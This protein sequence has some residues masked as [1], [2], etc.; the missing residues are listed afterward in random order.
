MAYKESWGRG[1]LKTKKGLSRWFR[2][3]KPCPTSGL[4]SMS[5]LWHVSTCL[6]ICM[7]NSY[8]ACACVE[9]G[10][11][12]CSHPLLPLTLSGREEWTGRMEVAEMCFCVPFV[13]PLLMCCSNGIRRKH[14][15]SWTRLLQSFVSSA[16]VL[17]WTVI[18]VWDPEEPQ[19]VRVDDTAP[20]RPMAHCSIRQL[21][22]FFK[23]SLY[24]NKIN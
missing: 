11:M 18:L 15:D 2:E 10:P 8:K 1:L 23:E 14:V 20:D 4:H 19:P 6:F 16:K 13:I 3:E 5:C 22:P 7:Q 17:G 12:G 24:L 21:C 9:L